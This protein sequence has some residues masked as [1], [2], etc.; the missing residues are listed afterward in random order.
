MHSIRLRGIYAT[1]LAALLREHGW[2]IVQPAEE[3]L[4]YT[5]PEDRFAPF[6]VEVKDRDDYQGVIVAG[7][8]DPVNAVKEVL[9]AELPDVVC[10]PLPTELG[11]IYVGIVHRRRA[12][13]YEID[14][15]GLT[16]FLPH[17]ELTRPL[18]RGAAIRVQVKEIAHSQPIVTTHVSLAGRFAV[19]SQEQGV[20]ISKEIADPEERE[21]LL[22]LGRRYCTNGWGVIWRTGAYRQDVRELQHEVKLL[23]QKLLKLEGHPDEG[24]PGK[25][26]AG[27]MALLVEFPGSSKQTLDGWRA[28]LIPTEPGYHL[29]QSAPGA[30]A[31][32]NLGDRIRIE[33]VK[34]HSD[35]SVVMAGQVIA[36]GPQ[37]ITVHREIKSVGLYDGLNIPK[38]PGDYAV[39]EFR[40]GAWHYETR[41]YSRDG[42]LK[43]I[44]VNINTPIEIYSDRVRCVDLEIDVVQCPG[45]PAQ[46]IDELDLQRIAHLVSPALIERARAVAAEL[47]QLL[48][49]RAYGIS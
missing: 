16:G 26:L 23:Q 11:A 37:Q 43:G 33:H 13:G 9:F 20:G 44:Y 22:S 24:I 40:H 21:R 34:T 31:L 3:L 12:W 7:E 39:T 14:L 45:E 29:Q 27:Q 4:P 47:V 1:A 35:L 15:G 5:G 38:E 42:S 48:N 6:D 25:V 19:L 18:R 49:A 46:L 32:P 8:A 30:T 36:V 17:T 2:R 41:Y 10:V 28:R